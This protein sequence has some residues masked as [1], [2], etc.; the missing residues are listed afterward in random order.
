MKTSGIVGCKIGWLLIS[1][2]EDGALYKTLQTADEL[3][4]AFTEYD[5]IFIDMP[6]GLED[7]N[8][9]RECDLLMRKSVGADYA[10]KVLTPPIR[11]ALDA[12]SYVEANMISFDYTEV[13]LSLETWNIVPKIQMVDGLLQSNPDFREKVLE[14]HPEF[15]LQ[16]LNGGVIF[17]K[18]NLKRG[19]RH[20]LE[21]VRDQEAIADDFF[22][23]IKEDYRRS[24]I[25]E[26][27]IVDAMAL[28]LFAKRSATKG[29]K[30]MPKEP[31]LDSKGLKK[32][33]HYV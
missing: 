8:L 18:S 29:L 33:Y 14:S 1:F 4:A 15:L 32:A 9:D 25:A 5:R 22:R 20:R 3:S 28:A 21:L 10:A 23:D 2:D 17:Q 12:P 24:E 31:T 7:E 30:T 16:K 27:A 11:P 19:V 6:I 13:Q 26:A